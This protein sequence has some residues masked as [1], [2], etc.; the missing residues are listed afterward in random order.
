VRKWRTEEVDDWGSGG[1]KK[2]RTGEVE[3]WG[4]EVRSEEV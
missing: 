2:W 4:M 1:L 3:N